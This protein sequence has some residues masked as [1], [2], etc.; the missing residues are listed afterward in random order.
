VSISNHTN[1]LLP[2]CNGGQH[3]IYSVVAKGRNWNEKEHSKQFQNLL[4]GN[5]LWHGALFSMVTMVVLPVL[6]HCSLF[7]KDNMWSWLGSFI[8]LVSAYTISEI[9]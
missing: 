5:V 1:Y 9:Q 8:N 6:G 7:L 3:R 2:K 4:Q